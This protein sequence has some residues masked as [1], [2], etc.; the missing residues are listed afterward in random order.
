MNLNLCFWNLN[1]AATHAI[2][3]PTLI[4]NSSR[5]DGSFHKLNGIAVCRLFLADLT[6]W[7]A[8]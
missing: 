7:I 2:D 5:S 6:H 8:E 4:E 3:Q 1:S